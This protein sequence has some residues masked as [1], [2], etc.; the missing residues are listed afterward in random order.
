MR[1]NAAKQY[2]EAAAECSAKVAA[3]VEE[4]QRLNRKYVDYA[5]D[6]EAN[7]YCLQN[8]NGDYPGAVANTDPPPWI[9]RVEDIFDKPQF[10]IDGASATDIH[11]GNGG[12]CWFLA[13]LMAISAKKELVEKLCVARDE[14]VGVYGFVFYRDGEWVSEVIDDKL[15]IKVGSG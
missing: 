11:Q 10:F 15:F 13:A 14:K 2:H 12:D 8:L 3:I 9:K 5:F 4:C 6:L 1:E 7:Q